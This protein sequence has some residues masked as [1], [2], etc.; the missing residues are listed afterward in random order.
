MQAE[1]SLSQTETLI[2]NQNNGL[3]N[4]I[5]WFNMI[6]EK[7]LRIFEAF[8]KNPLAELTR[9]QLKKKAKEKSN[10]AIAL[11]IKKLKQENVLT[12]RKIGKTGLLAVSLDNEAAIH[13]IAIANASSLG[14]AA[15]DAVRITLGEIS[16]A[17]PFFSLAVF[18]SYAEGKQKPSSDID[19]A[20]FLCDDGK[21]KQA[22]AAA[23]SAGL[24]SP[25]KADIHIIPAG[26]MLEMLTNSEENLGKQIAR[27]HLAVHNPSIFYSMLQEGIRHGFKP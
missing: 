11:F 12:E 22:E 25:I 5:Y 27:K 7:Q 15:N 19:I 20:V 16:S 21:K 17:T 24:K 13:Y 26:E 1:H 6:T 3:Y 9:S 8:A 4:P 2:N 10:N 14:K 18:G 23:N